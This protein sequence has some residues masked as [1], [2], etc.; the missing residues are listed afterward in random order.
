MRSPRGDDSY[1]WRGLSPGLRVRI[2]APSKRSDEWNRERAAARR[3]NG[4]SINLFMA[5]F[6]VPGLGAGVLLAQHWRSAWGLAVGFGSSLLVATAAVILQRRLVRRRVLALRFDDEG[7]LDSDLSC[8]RCGYDLRGMKERDECPEC[9]LNVH[10]SIYAAELA[11]TK[12]PL[13]RWMATRLYIAA[14]VASLVAF[15]L[16]MLDTTVVFPG[17]VLAFVAVFLLT[18]AIQPEGDR[19]HARSLH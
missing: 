10:R 19:S 12:P 15:V 2:E 9:G 5:L 14:V 7:R 13:A 18:K 11:A 1:N 16:L 17:F 6:Y 4:D 8:A 3:R